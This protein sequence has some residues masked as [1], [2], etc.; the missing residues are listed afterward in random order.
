MWHRVSQGPS[1]VVLKLQHKAG[2]MQRLAMAT[3]RRIVIDTKTGRPCFACSF[4]SNNKNAAGG[5]SFDTNSGQSPPQE[6][7]LKAISEVSKAEGRVAQTTNMVLGGT[8]TES[9]ESEWNVIDQK[10]NVYPMVREFTAIGIGGDE[11]VKAMVEA[12]E[13][14]VES[15][16]PEGGVSKK[17]SAQGKYVS[18]KIGGVTVSSSEQVRAVYDAMK[19]D[20]RMKYFL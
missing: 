5:G 16:V 18:V 14:I 8:V 15:P 7:V 1:D 11:F 2:A 3:H 4:S 12:V 9:S 20:V 6:A 19:K 13:S 17:L 10:V